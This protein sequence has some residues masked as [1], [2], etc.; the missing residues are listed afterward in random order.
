MTISSVDAVS[1]AQQASA[2]LSA[3]WPV[4]AL[5]YSPHYIAW[6]FGFPSSE[7]PP[8]AVAALE[9]G[10]WIGFLGSTPRRICLQ[11]CIADVSLVSFAAVHPDSR[12][13]GVAAALYQELLGRLASRGAA[14][15]TFAQRATAG[16]RV[17][18]RAYPAAGYRLQ[19]IGDYCVYGCIPRVAPTDW[20]MSQKHDIEFPPLGKAAPWACSLPDQAQL[21]HYARDP[22]PRRWICVERQGQ[23][24]AAWAVE[25][26]YRGPAGLSHVQTLESVWCAAEN[27]S[28]LPALAFHAGGG[29]VMAPN[30]LFWKPWLA[31]TGFRQTATVF[32]GYWAV[33]PGMDWGPVEGTNLEV[34]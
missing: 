23:R 9:G 6:Q 34:V 11:D 8:L 2:L 1:G 4:P 12:G 19:A 26:S 7:N 33:P 21:L 25:T 20:T 16:V 3:A 29:M 15:I 31:K 5:D 22:R 10:A 24:A 32:Q 14:V 18:E 13:R 27:A 28:A 30:V 17:I